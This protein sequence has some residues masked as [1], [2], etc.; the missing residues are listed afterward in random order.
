VWLTVGSSSQWRWCCTRSECSHCESMC[1]LLFCCWWSYALFVMHFWLNHS[2]IV[3]QFL[4]V[5]Q[6]LCLSRRWHLQFIWWE[7]SLSAMITL[8]ICF[9][10]KLTRTSI[11]STAETALWHCCLG[12]RKGI[13]PV[14]S[15][16]LV[17]WWWW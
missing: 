2:D 11:L 1:W 17:C 12:D 7:I 14:K 16:V 13:Q 10:Y 4:A 6:L 3:C 8:L 15:W 9:I 5:L